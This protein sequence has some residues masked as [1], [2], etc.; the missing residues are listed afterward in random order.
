MTISSSAIPAARA[1]G[2]LTCRAGLLAGAGGLP[3]HGV[4]PSGG[5]EDELGAVL[6]GPGGDQVDGGAPTDAGA[7]RHPL[8]DVGSG[9]PLVGRHRVAVEG[10][11]ARPGPGGAQHDAVAERHPHQVGERG[12]GVGVGGDH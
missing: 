9:R 8:D 3:E 4:S 2:R 7:Q 1:V 12:V 10:L 11:G 5:G 6:S